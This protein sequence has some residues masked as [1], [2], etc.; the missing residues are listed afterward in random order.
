MKV[1]RL[2]EWRERRGLSQEALAELAGVSRDGISSYENGRRE[3]HPGTAK[4]LADAV[5]YL[6]SDRASWITGA[7]VPVD[8]GQG[9]P[10][11]RP[12]T[13]P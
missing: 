3:A 6:L 8:G 7:N 11:A 13:A 4:K 1:P 9:R 5:A 12:F 2:K 10:N